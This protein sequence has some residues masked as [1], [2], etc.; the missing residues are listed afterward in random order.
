MG[1]FLDHIASHLTSLFIGKHMVEVV[2]QPQPFLPGEPDAGP[3]YQAQVY[4]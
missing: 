3:P 4:Y 2:A 1:K